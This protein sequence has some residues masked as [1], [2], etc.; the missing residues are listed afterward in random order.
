MTDSQNSGYAIAFGEA[1]EK[2]LYD[3]KRTRAH[4]FSCFEA[5]ML[6]PF[7]TRSRSRRNT[8]PICV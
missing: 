7:P 1:P 2:N 5:E 4:L 3:E 6:L 8:K